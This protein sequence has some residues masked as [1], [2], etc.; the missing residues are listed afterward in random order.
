[1]L[2]SYSSTSS[3]STGA[4]WVVS[5]NTHT[6]RQESWNPNMSPNKNSEMLETRNVV[7]STEEDS[8]LETLES[9]IKQMAQKI[10]EYRATLPDQLKNTLI[11][12]LAAQRPPFPQPS[13]LFLI[14]RVFFIFFLIFCWW[15][16]PRS[17]NL[18]EFISL[19]FFVWLSWFFL[20]LVGTK[21]VIAFGRHVRIR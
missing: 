20:F 7:Q 12:V 5:I 8:D 14:S 19:S 15:V 3:S 21:F 1:M 4:H 10:L 16:D 11:S 13:G 6:L 18:I 17:E 9:D 2:S